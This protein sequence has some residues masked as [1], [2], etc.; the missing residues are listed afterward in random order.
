MEP[1]ELEKEYYYHG[2]AS[3]PRLVARSDFATVSWEPRYEDN[4]P[5]RKEIQNIGNHDI[6][7]K[8]EDSLCDKIIAR[9]ESVD[10][11]S[12][13][14]V[15]IGYKSEN[16]API[17]WI[18]VKPGSLDSVNGLKITSLCRE[19]LLSA[20]LNVHCEI[21]EGSVQRLNG[22]PA[23]VIPHQYPGGGHR[24]ISLTSVLGG[25]R[26]AAEDSST[27]E[28]TLSLYLEVGQGPKHERITC[29]LTCRHVVFP[30]TYQNE[31]RD[32]REKQV[33]MPGQ[34]TFEAIYGTEKEDLKLWES[35][36]NDR[37]HVH[38]D[39]CKELI[40]HL[41]SLEHTSSRRIGH[42]L[43]SPPSLLAHRGKFTWL[44]DYAVI[45]LGRDRFGADYNKLNNTI[46][47]GSPTSNLKGLKIV[48]QGRL[49][50]FWRPA[51]KSVPLGDLF[52]I[53]DPKTQDD[54]VFVGKSGG[55]SDLT[56]GRLNE[57]KSVLRVNPG[58]GSDFIEVWH[59]VIIGVGGDAFSE[60]GDSGS[61]VWDLD[62][63]IVGILEAGLKGQ[64][65]RV[66]LTYATPMQW[67]M[68]H[69][70]ENLGPVSLL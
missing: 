54:P 2:L 40:T 45:A 70:K 50:P 25:Q 33:I 56:F 68:D 10:W 63:R 11:N 51:G 30:R 16:Y 36:K 23:T 65:P 61:V 64:I 62:G 48:N 49:K 29:A 31:V 14:V 9:L 38:R 34:K 8:W 28:G 52:E 57:I 39:A 41:A 47:I 6:V 43:F 12:I 59:W 24:P 60:E 58:G 26:I 5:V 15:R 69:I 20:G 21:H 13:D 35:Q 17:V 3:R 32:D 46:Y 67:I 55:A 4:H 19:D 44:P 7:G 27:K 1:S 42:V 22:P 66:D 37:Y 18:S 53:P